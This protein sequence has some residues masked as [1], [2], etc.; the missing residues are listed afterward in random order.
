MT[1]FW[2]QN[3]LWLPKS[4]DQ[5]MIIWHTSKIGFN[6]QINDWKID[7]Y[8][9]K[10]NMSCA[11]IITNAWIICMVKTVLNMV[12]LSIYKVKFLFWPWSKPFWPCTWFRHIR[13][14]YRIDKNVIHIRRNNVMASLFKN[15]FKI[16]SKTLR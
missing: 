3:S 13:T 7:Q 16:Y 15:H 12:N 4:R 8:P 11:I 6:L 14:S 5:K 1:N 2:P 10:W 9:S